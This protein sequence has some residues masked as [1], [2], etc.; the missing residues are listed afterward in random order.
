[1]SLLNNVQL[2][3]FHLD[4]VPH[5][6]TTV[7]GDYLFLYV[8]TAKVVGFND[9]SYLL[10][11]SSTSMYVGTVNTVT[12]GY[13]FVDA[14]MESLLPSSVIR[15]L[16]EYQDYKFD[17]IGL[18]PVS[19]TSAEKEEETGQELADRVVTE[20]SSASGKGN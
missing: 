7:S 15:I 14:R 2:L 1:M 19:G 4:G 8:D 18:A 5:F 9:F 16:Q 3:K 6:A 20:L 10:S 13:S 11:T 17:T 12:G